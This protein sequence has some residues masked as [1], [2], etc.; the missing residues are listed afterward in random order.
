MQFRQLLVALFSFS[1]MA[2]WAHEKHPS[3]IPP[4]DTL[5]L[6]ERYGDFL[7]NRYRSPFD[8]K[9]PAIV[10]KNVEYDPK[11][12]QY[13]VTEK[14]GEDYFRMPTYMTAQ[15][16]YKY[17][18]QQQERAMFDKLAG[19]GKAGKSKSAL[20]NPFSKIDLGQLLTDR[21]FGGTEVSIVPQGNIDLTIG[22]RYRNEANPVV[23][24]YQQRQLQ[25]DFNMDIQVNVTGKIGE[26]LSLTTSYNNK[27]AF[28]FDNVFKQ[29]WRDS[30]SR[31]FHPY[32]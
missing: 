21:L 24:I 2:V 6:K 29:D 7:N 3:L 23:P 20:V 11:T 4:L 10:E 17:K 16:Y 19:V 14:I 13:I 28:N 12:N 30:E 15:E 9:D 22:A 18:G 5:P 25:P 31:G 8:L 27:A 1:S 32:R 26:K